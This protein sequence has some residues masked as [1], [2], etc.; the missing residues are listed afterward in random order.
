MEKLGTEKEELLKA[1]KQSAMEKVASVYSPGH[2]QLVQQPYPSPF[3]TL[4]DMSMP[5][6]MSELFRLCK[7]YYTFDPLVAGAINALASFPITEVFLEESNNAKKV[8]QANM[9]KS[10]DNGVP[11]STEESDQLKQYK[12]VILDHL[13]IHKLLV[14]IGIDYWLYGNCFVFGELWINPVTKQKEWK[15]LVRLDPSKVIIDKNDATQEIRYKWTVP[16]RIKRIVKKKKPL[17]E[18]KKIPQII[19]DA[20]MKNQ[21]VLLNPNNIYHFS[22]PSDS[23]GDTMWGPPVIANVMKLLLY[24]NTLRQAQEAIAK[25]HIVPF[26]VYYFEQTPG[27]NPNGNMGNVV[28]SFG[29]EL[30][31]SSRDPNYKVISPVPVGVL[32]LG[33]NGKSLML[34]PEIEQVQAEILAGMCVPREFVFGG[35][36]WS[37]SSISLKILENQFITYR[38]LVHDFLQNFVVKNMARSRGE[39]SS[40]KDDD[41]IPTIEMSEIKMQDDVQQKQLIISL[42]QSGKLPDD[43]LWKTMGFDPDNMRESLKEEAKRKIELDEEVEILRVESQTRIQIAQIKAQMELQKIQTKL[44]TE[45]Q[46]SPENQEAQQVQMQQEMQMQQPQEQLQEQPQEQPQ[47]QPQEQPVNEDSKK[48]VS[49][50][51]KKGKKFESTGNPQIDAII[52]QLIKMPAS[53]A[54]KHLQALKGQLPNEIINQ[55]RAAVSN[56]RKNEEADAPGVGYLEAQKVAIQ[57]MKMPEEERNTMLAKLPARQRILVEQSLNDLLSQKPSGDEDEEDDSKQTADMRPMPQQRPPRRD[58]LK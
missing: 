39:W 30:A 28:E 37:G 38:L 2:G 46:L 6:K 34:T 7:Y 47:K 13:G 19:K 11:S 55:I 16:D 53:D 36:S 43:I 22:R 51:D 35:M 52:R 31:K 5:S 1:E 17:S 32:N 48:A 29:K 54:L 23:M 24:R 42:N 12:R 56:S 20:V 21:A 10:T 15:H 4:S 18:Y 50:K 41:N 49:T 27:Y 25:E 57:L 33:G 44:Q 8:L 58:S 40:D 45:F 14:G 9:E 26:R 3:M